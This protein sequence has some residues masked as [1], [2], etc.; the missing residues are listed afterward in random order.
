[1]CITLYLC[2]TTTCV[3][4]ALVQ[5]RM[6]IFRNLNVPRHYL[7]YSCQV[8]NSTVSHVQYKKYPMSCW[9][10]LFSCRWASCCLPILGKD[11]LNLR[12]RLREQLGQ[13]LSKTLRD[14][15][16]L[17]EAYDAQ[18]RESRKENSRNVKGLSK[19]TAWRTI[20][21]I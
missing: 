9:L 7:K 13:W 3:I 8:Y 5:C 1:M 21:N 18:N 6:S 4:G 10:Y 14:P 15:S 16:P 19:K 2:L 11:Q 12:V 17:N 20:L